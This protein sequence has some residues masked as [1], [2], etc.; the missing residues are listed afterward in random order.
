MRTATENALVQVVKDLR[1]EIKEMR[2]EFHQKLDNSVKKLADAFI[3]FGILDPD[4]DV[5]T[6]KQVC[7]HYHVDRRTMYNYR[8]KN[9]IPYTKT[10]NGRN[11]RISYRKA[12][13]IEFFASY[14]KE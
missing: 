7:K 4:E 12:D 5:W 8:E 11:C 6:E 2:A 9:L 10:G 13:V 1:A 14:N 3:G